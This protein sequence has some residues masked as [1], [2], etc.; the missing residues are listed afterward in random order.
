MFNNNIIISVEELFDHSKMFVLA[1]QNRF[2]KSYFCQ[3]V[4]LKTTV[5]YNVYVLYYNILLYSG[6]PNSIIPLT[7]RSSRYSK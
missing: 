3:T 4:L 6:T 7:K 5:Y 2:E 1:K